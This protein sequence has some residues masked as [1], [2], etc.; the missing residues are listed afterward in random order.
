MMRRIP[1]KKILMS[2]LVFVCFFGLL[3]G[4]L[5]VLGI[6]P[7]MYSEDPY[8]GFSSHSPLFV[9]AQDTEGNEIYRVADEKLRLFNQ[10]E[11]PAIKKEG[12]YRIFCMGGSTTYGRPFDDQTSFCGWLRVMLPAVDPSR[13]WEV[14]N[15]GGVSYASYRVALLMEE[16]NRYKPDLFIIYS[17]QNEF[18]EARTYRDIIAMPKA[19]RGLGALAAHTRTWSLMATVLKGR[20]SGKKDDAPVLGDEV[21][22]RL[23]DSIGPSDYHRDRLQRKK[24]IEHF[25]FNLLRMI[26]IG[27]SGGAAV[28]MIVPTANLADCTPFKSEHSPGME[29]DEIRNFDAHMLAARQ[30]GM[31]G[32]L[33][34]AFKELE[35]ARGLDQHYAGELYNEARVLQAM[36]RWDEALEF[37]EK[38][39][40]EDVCPLR[41]LGEMTAIVRQV[42]AERR[43]PLVDFDEAIRKK[44]THE[45]PGKEF[46]LDHVHPTI[47][48]H[49]LLARLI[50]DDLIGQGIVESEPSE[51]DRILEKV[52]GAVLA[53]VDDERRGEALMKL[54]K[55]LG[56]AGKMREARDLAWRAVELAPDSSAVWYQAGLTAQLLGKSGDA[57]KAYVR[58][59]EIQPDAD[60]PHQNLGVIL[61]QKGQIDKAI[62]HFREAIRLARGTE[63]ISANT[64]NLAD[65]LMIQGNLFFRKKHFENALESFREAEN[66]L[67]GRPACLWRLGMAE[68]NMGLREEA[69]Q[70]MKAAVAAAPGDGAMHNRL[71]I[72]YAVNGMKEDAI[73]EFQ[74]ALRLKPEIRDAPD[75]MPRLLKRMKP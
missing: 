22:T 26:D 67:P 25:H 37:F 35:K 4:L 7:R 31:K 19:F 53:L 28:E 3:E 16:L 1:W 62:D 6:Q 61:R 58:A 27:R 74:E 15:A 33:E 21:R 51:I 30:A 12:S 20:Q 68:L 71:A 40:D 48:G 23:D 47:E 29:K 44:S 52:H 17:G 10:Q 75:A 9:R 46:L 2:A 36:G 50:L 64:E 32:D 66:L 39:K 38:A 43:T 42:A 63:T 57:E 24:T 41:I 65:A 8:V 54:S 45:I 70:S 59:L 72:V 13:K 69:L 34:A 60:L 49:Y 55:V 11:F 5:A 14:I 18:L 73:R 56:W